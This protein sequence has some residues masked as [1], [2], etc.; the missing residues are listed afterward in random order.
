[1][2]PQHPHATTDWQLTPSANND[3]NAGKLPSRKSSLQRSPWFEWTELRPATSHH[4]DHEDILLPVCRLTWHMVSTGLT[5]T[6]KQVRW[7][8]GVAGHRLRQATILCS[9][10]IHDERRRKILTN[11]TACDSDATS[12]G[13]VLVRRALNTSPRAC[14]RISKVLPHVAERSHIVNSKSSGWN[15]TF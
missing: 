10:S 7:C 2:T 9:P 4:E 14:C 12:I 11:M 6:M 3:H 1:M 15:S 13:W 5:S 8:S